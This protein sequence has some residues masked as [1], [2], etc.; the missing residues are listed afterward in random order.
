MLTAPQDT[1][2]Q[3]VPKGA[4]KATF[5]ILSDA[6]GPLPVPQFLRVPEL[7]DYDYQD[8]RDVKTIAGAG[9][10]PI[11]LVAGKEEI[12]IS[13]TMAATFGKMLNQ[14]CYGQEE[15][16]NQHIFV[17]DEVGYV[18]PSSVFTDTRIRSC[19]MV[20]LGRWDSHV[21]VKINNAAASVVTMPAA[22]QVS[23][24]NGKYGFNKADLGKQFEITFVSNGVTI[25]QTG[26]ITAKLSHDV[27]L[28]TAFYV[29]VKHDT[30]VL[31]SDKWD[32][33]ATGVADGRYQV[34]PNGVFLFSGTSNLAI[35]TFMHFTHWTDGQTC[36]SKI[37][38]AQW[39]AAAC[40]FYVD[41]PSA[42]MFAAP[43]AVTLITNTGT[44]M[45]GVAVNADMTEDT[46]PSASGKYSQDDKGWYNFHASDVGDIVRISYQMDYYSINPVCRNFR[47]EVIDGD[48]FRAGGVYNA[49]GKPLTRVAITSPL[50][51]GLDQYAM[52]DKTG[53]TYLA[54]ENARE[55]IYIDAE[56][57]TTGGS[58]TEVKQSA[59]GLAPV[60]R[61]VL[62][63]HEPD[64]Q[65]LLTF[66]RA[67]CEGMGVKTKTDDAAEVFKFSF[68]CAVDRT[69]GLSHA[70]NTSS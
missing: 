17:N 22:G 20:N 48:F 56:F 16:A 59:A 18:V 11:G 70:V 42:A 55:R 38:D 4:G 65:M 24:V 8:K 40:Q 63:N 5:E 27:K 61:I 44:A 35:N 39:P 28:F 43:V 13:L 68:K 14:L 9:T 51:I 1:L 49:I 53:A 58:R 60:V 62:N 6:N 67:M 12:T 33:K 2:P 3:T 37:A 45:T 64:Q 23:S 54:N 19:V 31:A 47:G 34:S 26:R 36:S 15:S 29:T 69:T 50:S 52:D 10:R 57:E 41:P 46:T 30:T 7:L 66:E 25:I 21:G 32:P